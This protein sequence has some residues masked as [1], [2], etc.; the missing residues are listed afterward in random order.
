MIN[1]LKRPLL[2]SV[3]RPVLRSVKYPVLENVKHSVLRSVKHP[4]LRSVKHPVL[5]SVK[6]SVLISVKHPVLRSVFLFPLFI[7]LTQQARGLIDQFLSVNHFSGKYEARKNKGLGALHCYLL[8]ESLP[9][10][11]MCKIWKYM[12][13]LVG[14]PASQTEIP[15][16]VGLSTA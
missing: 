15:M 6:H 5:R 9:I 11:E 12:S 16:H 4:V 8:E 7:R 13:K 3:K 1:I 14:Q 2:R 10:K